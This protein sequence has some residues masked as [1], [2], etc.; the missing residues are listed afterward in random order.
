M[1]KNFRLDLSDLPKE[2][3]L[4]LELLRSPNTENICVNSQDLLTD[5][6]WDL[7][8]AQTKHHRVYPILNTKIKL[9]DEDLI[10]PFVFQYLN[11]Q[12][13]KNTFQMLHLS[14]EMEQVCKLFSQEGIRTLFLKG[15]VLAQELYGDISLRTSSDVDFLIPIQELEQAE[16]LLV[17]LGYEKD[18]YIETV[19]NDW[20]WRHH[21]VTYFHPY[22]RIKLEVHWRLNPGPGKEPTF[23][24]LWERKSRSTLTSSPIYLLGREDLFLFLVSHG[25]RHGWSR[26]RWLIDIKQLMKQEVKWET[27]YKLL[28]S[29]G[30][31][32]VGGQGIILALQLLHTDFLDEMG[33]MLVSERSQ[34]LAQEAIF[35]LETMVNLH[36]D[37]VPEDVAR[38][39]KHHLF[40]LMSYRQ[41]FFFIIS[42]LHP[43][44]ED[45][46][47]L[48]L[49][50][51]LHFL[52]FPLRPLLWAWRKTRKHA[53]P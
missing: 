3:R 9:L 11:Q 1:D 15:P 44:P 16:E 50:E 39:H 8:I 26:L 48:P 22:K 42:F 52:Y 31:H 53:L 7:F 45:A 40:S 41:K 27:A 5:I 13:K 20:R 49:P 38:Y 23:N 21:H 51:K 14:A 35:Y 24:E 10:P 33:P 36:T 4:I 46:E 34:R 19:L 18:D 32:H 25:A 17:K 12:Y 6:D 28:K 30:Y 2:L 47:T 37:P 29:Y 43:Y